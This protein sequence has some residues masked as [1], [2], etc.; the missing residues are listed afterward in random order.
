MYFRAAHATQALGLSRLLNR[1]VLSFTDHQDYFR[2]PF[3][4]YL[5]IL[6]GPP[7]SGQ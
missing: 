3:S 1:N 6:L 7:L 2:V 4:R 5:W